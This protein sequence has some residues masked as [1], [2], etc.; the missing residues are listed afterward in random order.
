[1]AELL[2]ECLIISLVMLFGINIGLIIGNA[3]ISRGKVL[4]ISIINGIIL[5]V[6]SLLSYYMGFLY[7]IINNYIPYV[8]GLIGVITILN[9]LY[10]IN[11]WRKDKGQNNNNSLSLIVSSVCFFSGF[12][13]TAILLNYQNKEFNSWMINIMAAI[14]IT[15]LVTIFYHFSKFLRHA[16]RPYPVLLGNYMILNGFYF[17]IAG[18]FIPNIKSLNLVQMNSLSVSSTK[19]MIFLIIA[20]LGVLLVGVYLKREGKTV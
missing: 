19:S 1:M 15:L 17:L 2:W 7:S 13:F 16:E 14:S 5:F 4:M 12:I 8:V 18:F 6:L 9:G 20:G 3:Q 10:T 11:R